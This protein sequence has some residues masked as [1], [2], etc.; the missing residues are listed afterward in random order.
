MA[1]LR[2]IPVLEDHRRRNARSSQR[3]F[4]GPYQQRT[5]DRLVEL[6]TSA[7]VL[8]Y[9]DFTKPFILHTD[10]SQDGLGAVLYQ[11]Q[12]TRKKVIGYVSRRMNDLESHYPAHK[13]EF[14][15]LK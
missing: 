3:F 4:L 1:Y 2:V 15:S 7:P 6:L 11:D 5:F 10:A 8:A 12:S 13:L 14:I 9:A